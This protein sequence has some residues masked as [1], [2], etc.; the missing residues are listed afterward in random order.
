M[1]F[2]VFVVNTYDALAIYRIDGMDCIRMD[3]NTKHVGQ[4]YTL[5]SCGSAYGKE[6]C[7]QSQTSTWK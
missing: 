6:I 3:A 2:Q 4:A 5:K 1:D 7:H